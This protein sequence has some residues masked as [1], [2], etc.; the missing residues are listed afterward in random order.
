MGLMEDQSNA[1]NGMSVALTVTL[2]VEGL[3]WVY[4]YLLPFYFL[5]KFRFVLL[6]RQE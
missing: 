4:L 3:R 1:A 5:D 6:N 2:F